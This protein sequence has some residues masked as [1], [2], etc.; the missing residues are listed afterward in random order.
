MSQYSRGPWLSAQNMLGIPG[1]LAAALVDVVV[2]GYQQNLAFTK[3]WVPVPSSVI[4]AFHALSHGSCPTFQ[5]G[6]H[7]NLPILYTQL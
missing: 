7:R 6:S 2:Y 1:R 5:G 4:S 3:N